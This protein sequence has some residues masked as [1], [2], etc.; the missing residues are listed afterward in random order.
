MHTLHCFRS[1]GMGETNGWTDG[2]I[3]HRLMPP[4]TSVAGQ[5][6]YVS[7]ETMIAC[8]EQDINIHICTFLRKVQTV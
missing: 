4:T 6:M 2:R 3:G 8:L 5:I 1:R 7:Y